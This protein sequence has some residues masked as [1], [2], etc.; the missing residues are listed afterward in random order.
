[1]TTQELLDSQAQRQRLL[2]L[3]QE[4]KRRQDRLLEIPALENDV[5]FYEDLSV[6]KLINKNSEE[7]NTSLIKRISDASWSKFVTILQEEAQ[8]VGTLLV[9][10]DPAYTSQTC[11]N[12][13]NS[14]NLFEDLSVRTATCDGCKKELDRDINASINILNRG[15]GMEPRLKGVRDSYL[16]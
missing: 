6:K 1:M 5:I 10:V 9:S 2:Y 11:H 3:M 8:K 13:G 14:K 7:K 15:L 16:N 12:C 4:K